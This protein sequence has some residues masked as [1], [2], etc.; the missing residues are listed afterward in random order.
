MIQFLF[1]VFF[2]FFIIKNEA[3]ALSTQQPPPTV[4]SLPSEDSICLS[5]FHNEPESLQRFDLYIG[6]QC[7]Y[8]CP[9]NPDKKEYKILITTA[10]ASESELQSLKTITVQPIPKKY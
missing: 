1:C 9:A 8:R 2:A 5:W 7:V 4:Q 3:E 6:N 10:N